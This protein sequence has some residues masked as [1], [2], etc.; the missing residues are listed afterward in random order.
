[1][2]FVDKS[3]KQEE[4]G[5]PGSGLHLDLER[6]LCPDCGKEAMPWQHSCPDCG[7]ATVTPQQMPADE[8]P[9]PP[10]LRDLA[11]AEDTEDRE[12]SADRDDS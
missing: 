7:S 3:R 10:G 12:A 2:A 4:E 8:F 9:L 1:M 5:L 11:E 6:R